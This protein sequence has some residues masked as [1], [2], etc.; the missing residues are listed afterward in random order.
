MDNIQDQMNAVLNDPE[1]MQKIMGLAQSLGQ[2]QPEAAVPQQN[3]PPAAFP[4]L[5]ISTLQ[6]LST[7]AGS[8]GIDKNQR[9]LLSALRPYLSG[10][11]ISKLEK[12][13]RAAKLANMASGLLGSTGFQFNTGR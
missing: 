1:M 2:S 4:E 7:L 3:A 13:M 11:R 6:K 5:D 12:A 9:S 10:D 8:T